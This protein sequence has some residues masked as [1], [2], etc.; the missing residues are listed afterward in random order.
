MKKVLIIGFVWPEPT[1]T[2]AG[3]RMLQLINTLQIN[4]YS[5]TFVSTASKTS[6]S[7][8]LENLNIET[9]EIKLNDPSFDFLISKL[10]PS[11]VL[12]DRFLTEEQFGWR[13][14]EI[15]PN[16]LRILDSEDLHFLRA[17]RQIAHK[18]NVKVSLNLL[19]NNTA[20]RELASIYRCDLTL[21]ISKYEMNLLK[22]TFK[23]DES[24]L[25]YIP[26]L[27]NQNNL[28][29]VSNFPSFEER[30]HFMTIGNFRHE[31]NWNAVL[32]LKT[33]VWPL[34]KQKLPN[35]KMFIYGAYS[36][37]KVAQLNNIKDGFLIKGWANNVEDVF[38]NARVCLA[39][40]QFGAGLKGKL[41]EAMIYGTPSVTSSIGAEAM[42]DNFPWNG[43]IS[44]T[45]IDF[46]SKAVELYSNENTWTDAQQNGNTI[47]KNC[48]SNVLFTHD[49]LEK[50]SLLKKT[51]K[52]HRLK[53]IIGTVLMHH[54]LQSTKY[55]S[56]WIEEKNKKVKTH[57]N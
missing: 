26:F 49:L 13:I 42:H 39:P 35:T 10:N 21:I 53:N 3:S 9:F 33:K 31:P 23:V 1:S 52:E 37:D 50:I 11:I 38:K 45:P 46:A 51:I 15:C 7:F 18:E 30:K 19:M 2:A 28:K 57:H 6:T 20:K 54:S 47:L 48:Y 24:L 27:V 16:A 36:S 44:N 29:P 43:F 56:K 12:F 25:H 32:H 34:I 5:I 55:L 14:N 22:N 4:K 41:I 8:N 17:A 40:I